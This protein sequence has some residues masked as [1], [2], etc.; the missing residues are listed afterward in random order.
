MGGLFG[1]NESSNTAFRF[2][3]VA[4]E[5]CD[6]VDGWAGVFAGVFLVTAATGI[7]T[8]AGVTRGGSL[9]GLAGALSA[10]S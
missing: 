2:P 9:T 8:D 3:L 10:T 6:W 1:G 5:S 7:D 4:I